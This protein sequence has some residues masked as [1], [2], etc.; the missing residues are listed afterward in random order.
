[1]DAKITNIADELSKDGKTLTLKIDL[2]RTLGPSVSGK[3]MLIASTK[4]DQHITL[5]DGR[6]V[7]VGV[8][9]YVKK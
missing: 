7:T 3:T 2:T 1:M 6:T 9:V 5:P 8:N 4:G